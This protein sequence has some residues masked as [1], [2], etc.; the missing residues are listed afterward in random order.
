MAEPA[1]PRIVLHAV[2]DVGFGGSLRALT[3]G[4]GAKDPFEQVRS[5]LSGADILFGNLETPLVEDGSAPMTAEV[6][7]GFGG[8][9]SSARFL[10]TAGFSI[11]SLA[12]N[13]IMDYGEEGMRSTF[14]AL[15][16]AGV[17]RVGC[18]GSLRESREPVIVTASGVKVG[19][20]AYAMKGR[21]SS[22]VGKPGAA[23]L[24]EAL[25]LEDLSA[26]EKLAEIRVVSLHFGLIY[27]DYPR[28][29]DQRLARRICE[30]GAHVVLG[31]HPHVL[32]GIERHRECLIAYSL[33][34]L[35]FDPASGHVVNRSAEEVRRDSIVLRVEVSPAGVVGH[36][37]RSCRREG[38]SRTPGA[39]SGNAAVAI[40]E[41]IE[42]LSRPLEGDGLRSRES[43]VSASGRNVA[44]QWDVFR[45]HL[46][47]GN[48]TLILRWLARM[49]PRHLK[50]ALQAMARRL[51]KG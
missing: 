35:L 33:G 14:R 24:T 15:D 21:H 16:V 6:P 13:H 23:P 40:S 22:A 43:G 41:R 7:A 27:E 47:R 11:V 1:G 10:A 28:W 30:A 4:T 32:Q 44:H 49:R 34:E 5:A 51:R 3:T 31:H 46:R 9:P 38:F 42:R 39:V 20:L 25:V 17:R 19:F 37:V 29:E 8:D 26:L 12:N 2:G 18:G 36:E 48:L 45:H 50:M